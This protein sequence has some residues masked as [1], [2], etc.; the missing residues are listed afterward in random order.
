LRDVSDTSSEPE[1]QEPTESPEPESPEP[2]SFEESEDKPE[3]TADVESSE[4]PKRQ[5]RQGAATYVSK[6]LYVT[7]IL[8]RYPQDGATIP[9]FEAAFA[10]YLNDQAA[11]GEELVAVT[12]NGGLYR[13]FF[14][15]T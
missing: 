4:E 15:K 13:F 1:S 2:F 6:W 14:K 12:E 7:D 10:A 11:A 5:K 8:A 3:A 9:E